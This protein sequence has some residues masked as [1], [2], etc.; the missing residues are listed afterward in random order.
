M[1]DKD[2]L[3]KA[4]MEKEAYDHYYKIIDKMVQW[5]IYNQ[6]EDV[7]VFFTVYGVDKTAITLKAMEDVLN[8]WKENE[9]IQKRDK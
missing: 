6:P 1:H 2:K 5:C 4:T 9:S 3:K 7:D 8:K